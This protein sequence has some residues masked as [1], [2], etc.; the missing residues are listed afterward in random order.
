MQLSNL[1]WQLKLQAERQFGVKDSLRVLVSDPQR[2]DHLLKRA[3]VSGNPQLKKLV[4]DIRLLQTQPIQ[5]DAGGSGLRLGLGLG[6][7]AVVLAAIGLVWV[8]TQRPQSGGPVNW[9]ERSVFR[10]HGSNTVG[11]RLAPALVEA[12]MKSR[13]ASAVEVRPSQSPVERQFVGAFD[14]LRERLVVDIHA[15]GS[16]TAFTDLAKGRADIG[17]SSRRIK[18][19]EVAAL[20]PSLGRLTTAASEHVVGLDG[21]AVIV[22]AGN[23]MV[24][25]TIERVA[26]IFSGEVTDWGQIAGG[27]SGP[28]RLHAR[29]DKSGT[30]DTFDSLVLKAKAKKLSGE[31]KRYESSTELANAVAADP[32]AIGFVGLPYVQNN[33]A[34]GISESETSLAVVPTA[35]TV[36]TEDYPLSRRLY[37]YAEASPKKAEVGEFIR[38]ALS[39]AGQTVVTRTG[40]ISLNIYP[41]ALPIDPAAPKAYR[42]LVENAQRLS[43]NFR[44]EAG[45]DQLDNRAQRDI[46]RLVDYL[47]ANPGRSLMLLGFSNSAEAGQGTDLSLARARQVEQALQSRGVFAAAVR[48]F[49]E[50]SPIASNETEAGR[51]RNRRVEAWLR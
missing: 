41:E 30:F 16:S 36:G 46:D 13:G 50:S 34:L 26:E 28:I 45:S 14:L 37:L 1:I 51:Q 44:F 3:E 42:E 7:F 17:M 32:L 18:S 29:D 9:P 38:F 43:L 40:L 20:E 27:L 25:M 33:K 23:P 8:L 48:G 19:D 47:A 6:L 4:A 35:F 31:A 21:L 49:G 11:E 12:W 10:I 5:T 22:H 24:S 2:L 15:H 39:S